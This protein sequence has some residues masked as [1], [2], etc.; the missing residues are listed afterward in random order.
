[1]TA[2][3]KTI[4]ISIIMVVLLA[5]GDYFVKKASLLKD[6]SGWHFLLIGTSSYFI[7]AFGLFWVYRSY[8]FVTV[9]AIQSFGIVV[10]SVLLSVFVFKEKMNGWEVLGLILGVISLVILLYNGKI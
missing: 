8:K 10:L 7:S 3:L 1:M 9:G 4:L 5:L 6:Y 2:L